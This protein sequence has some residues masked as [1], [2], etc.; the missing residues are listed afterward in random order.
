MAIPHNETKPQLV[1]EGNFT[2][3]AIDEPGWP[4][5]VPT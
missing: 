3:L 2:Y 1:T 5:N 4:R